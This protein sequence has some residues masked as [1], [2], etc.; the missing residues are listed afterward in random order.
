MNN[1][2]INILLKKRTINHIA[3][4]GSINPL[5]S[6]ISDKRKKI[7]NLAN[8]FIDKDFYKKYINSFPP[9]RFLMIYQNL[10][11]LY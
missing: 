5:H 10:D 11:L 7:L 6:S 9:K 3:K 1:M 2:I 8:I 4:F